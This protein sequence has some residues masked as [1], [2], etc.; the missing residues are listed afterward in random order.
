MTEHE[1]TEHDRE[2][3]EASNNKIV[4]V[5]RIR[6]ARYGAVLIGAGL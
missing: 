6:T 4:K 3:R 1:M 5:G 2:E